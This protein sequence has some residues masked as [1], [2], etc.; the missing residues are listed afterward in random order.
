MQALTEAGEPDHRTEWKIRLY[1]I[2]FLME[3]PE[4]LGRVVEIQPEEGLVDLQFTF[5][6]ETS[7]ERAR[8]EKEH[9]Q[10]VHL[11]LAE[12]VKAQA[13]TTAEAASFTAGDVE[14]GVGYTYKDVLGNA[15][16]YGITA[17][18]VHKVA[19]MDTIFAAYHVTPNGGN[20][21]TGAYT[22]SQGSP[23]LI[24]SITGN[25][26]ID[27]QT[28]VIYTT[29]EAAKNLTLQEG[30]SFQYRTELEISG[31]V[32][33]MIFRAEQISQVMAGQRTYEVMKY[34][35]Y[36]NGMTTVEGWYVDQ[37]EKEI[38]LSSLPAGT[39]YIKG[40]NFLAPLTRPPSSSTCQMRIQSISNLGYSGC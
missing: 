18:E 29:E 40:D 20:I 17:R 8:G 4:E 5:K 13:S 21:T 16:N 6:R 2:A 1:D 22:G 31:Q 32:E 30:S 10:V 23:L 3:D 14:P 12:P 28:C 36:W 37:N 35:T 11:P 25:L 9:V 19:H 7:S 34:G 24:G 33:N 15:V 26:S 38:D 27:G 39:Y